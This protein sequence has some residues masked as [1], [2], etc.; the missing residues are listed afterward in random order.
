MDRFYKIDNAYQGG[1]GRGGLPVPQVADRRLLDVCHRFGLADHFFSTVLSSSFPN[2][3]V[4][5]SGQS[6]YTVGNPHDSGSTRSWG[7]D[8]APLT[9]VKTYRN[10]K[11]HEVRPC[12]GFKTLVDEANTAGVSWKYYAPQQGAFGYIWSTLDAIKQIRN[13][14]K[15]WRNVVPPGQFDTDVQFGKSACNLMAGVRPQDQRAPAN[16]RVCGAGLDGRPHQSRSCNR[17][18][19][20][21]RPSSLRGT[22]SVASTI[23]SHHRTS[24]C[25]ALGPRVPTIVISPY[26]RARTIAHA[27]RLSLNRQVCRRAVRTASS[28]Y[29]QSKRQSLSSMLDTSQAP[30]SPVVLKPQT[31][32]A[33]SAAIRPTK[34]TPTW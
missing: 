5:I 31:C 14:P 16:E 28:S 18:Y 13:K 7:C 22:I 17:R 20:A 24:R 27:V 32:P 1:K 30:L 29:L 6:G 11:Y 8:A 15:Q 34:A 26:S 21:A 12:F 23:M 33:A 2:H 25:I 3:L 10:G 9:L 4:T 19:G